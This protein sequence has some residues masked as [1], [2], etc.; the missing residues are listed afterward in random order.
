MLGMASKSRRH[1]TPTQEPADNMHEVAHLDA[2]PF[3]QHQWLVFPGVVELLQRGLAL[4]ACTPRLQRL[5]HN[6]DAV[7]MPNKHRA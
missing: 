4:R 6:R 1:S 5:S 7:R 2:D 3:E